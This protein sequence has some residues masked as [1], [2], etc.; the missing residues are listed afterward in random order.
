MN[1]L[2]ALFVFL[3]V[4]GVLIFVHEAGHFLAAKAAGVHVH[5][6][7]LGLGSP[8]RRL[9]WTRGGTE[10]SI[11]WLPLGGYVKMATA[12]E[13]ATSSALE[14]VTPK[15]PVPPGAMFEAK[16]VWA[17]MIVILAGV[18]MNAVFAWGAF[19]FLAAK[20]GQQIDPATAVGRVAVD[21]LPAGAASL[22]EVQPGERIV[23]V[24]GKSVASWNEIEQGIVSTPGEE[25]RIAFAGGK[26]LA[27]PIHSS[28]LD[29]RVRASQALQPYRSPVIG[30]VLPG[31][32]GET[33]GLRVGDTIVSV[34][35]DSV[36]QWYDL[37][38][39]IRESPG[40]V[41]TFAIARGGG[42]L[43]I[44]LTPTAESED[45]PGGGKRQVGKIGVGPAIEYH[46]RR[47]SLSQA[48][49][50]GANATLTASTQ[51]VRTVHG[52]LS[53]RINTREVGGPILIGQMAA[54]SARLGLD[55][56]LAFMGFVSVNLAVLNLLPI[57][58]LDGGQ[59]I[60]LL[61]EAVNR[62]PLSLKLRERLT[63]VG[64]V[65]IGLLM[66]LAFSNDI[67]RLIG[68]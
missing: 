53:G 34:N 28:A 67:R 27:L 59:F 64:L 51:I 7:S 15:A 49:L 56:F 14:G 8:I 39:R 24:G 19:T 50:A 45:E 18:T 25:V 65:L 17:R 43:E 54:Q 16:P 4:L 42:R 5:R 41:L 36:R 48:L 40:Q 58:V 3:V 31:R 46:T 21:S 2:F 23:A 32:P 52:L 33:A 44:T 55:A 60:F 6:F 30:Q 20:N 68:W 26:E 61:A 13:E 47:Y 38:D 1:F 29:D 57:P 9:T 10:Y 62:K 12:E 63:F 37:V 22:R 35:G 11:S 66:V